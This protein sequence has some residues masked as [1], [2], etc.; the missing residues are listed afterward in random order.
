[1]SVGVGQV[2]VRQVAQVKIGRQPVVVK[3]AG[4]EHQPVDQVRAEQRDR[5]RNVGP[6]L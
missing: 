3:V 4:D 1:L 5:K 6:S 2:V